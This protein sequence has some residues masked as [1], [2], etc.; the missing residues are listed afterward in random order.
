MDHDICN[1]P[2]FQLVK[3]EKKVDK[4]KGKAVEVSRENTVAGSSGTMVMEVDKPGT[5][6]GE[7]VQ[8]LDSPA[9]PE[10]PKGES[11]CAITGDESHGGHSRSRGQGRKPR[12]RMQSVTTIN[13][14]SDNEQAPSHPHPKRSRPNVR[15]M[16]IPD[17]GYKWVEYEDRCEKCEQRGRQCAAYAGK[18]CW[19]CCCSKVACNFLNEVRASSRSRSQAPRKS[20]PH[21]WLPS[22]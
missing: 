17:P 14:D 6:I 10:G 22:T 9:L 16:L 11:S 19:Q 13:T 20:A 21:Q 8:P 15:D 18:A 12:K 5:H 2:W 4:G 3:S 7:P 1:H